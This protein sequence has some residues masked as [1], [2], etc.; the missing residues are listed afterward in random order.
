MKRFIARAVVVLAILAISPLAIAQFW[1]AIRL[2][3]QNWQAEQ[4]DGTVISLHQSEA[5]AVESCQRWALDNIQD[6]IVPVCITR[7]N[8][9]IWRPTT[10][11]AQTIINAGKFTATDSGVIDTRYPDG[12]DGAAPTFEWAT[13]P[14]FTNKVEGTPF[15]VDLRATYLTEP[16]T[17]DATLSIIGCTLSGG[18]SF[19]SPD[20]AYSDTGT[21]SLTGCQARAVREGVTVDSNA[22]SVESVAAE[23][24]GTDTTAPTQIVIKAVDLDGSDQPVISFYAPA[25]PEVADE[26]VSGLAT[27]TVLRD[28][29]PLTPT[30]FTGSDTPGLTYTAATVGTVNNPSN[31]PDPPLGVDFTIG[32]DGGNS[33][34]GSNFHWVYA[35]VA[36]DFTS[37]IKVTSETGGTQA[38]RGGNL[39]VREGTAAGSRQVCIHHH[40]DSGNVRSY[41]RNTT[42][43]AVVQDGLTAFTAPGC[44]AIT[45]IGSVI[46]TLSS[47]DTDCRNLAT[48]LSQTLNLNPTVLV[49][50]A[51]NSN[52]NGTPVSVV[53]ANVT[54]NTLPVQ[55]FT[56]TGATAGTTPS[57][58]IISDDVDGNVA[59]ASA[60]GSI[61]V[62]A[63]SPPTGDRY[64][65]EYTDPVAGVTLLGGRTNT[66]V[67]VGQLA[68][69]L[70][71]QDCGETLQLADG[72]HTG[73]HTI[74]A[75]CAANNPFVVECLN[76]LQCTA[77]GAWTMGG[78]RNIVTGILFSGTAVRINIGGT[79]NKFIANEVTGSNGGPNISLSRNGSTPEV[80]YNEIHTPAGFGGATTGNRQA[81]RT[82]DDGPADFPYDGWIHHNYIHDWIDKPVPT[83]YSSGQTDA[84]EICET[85]R[86]DYPTIDS[87]YWIEY[88]RIED[89]PQGTQIGAATVDFKCGGVVAAYNTFINVP[90]NLDQRGGTLHGSIF[91][92]NYFDVNSDG[93]RAHGYDNVF[94]GNAIKNTGAYDVMSG[95]LTG[96]PVCSQ[97]N[98]AG[99]HS[100]ASDNR[101]SGN[102]GKLIV[103][104][105]F[106]PEGNYD[107]PARNTLIEQHTGAISLI[108]GH[109]TGTVDNRNSDTAL[110]FT[111]AAILPTT[112][113]GPDALDDA[114]AAYKA[115]RGF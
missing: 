74:N 9:T 108:A 50:P 45:R 71:D 104:K 24:P 42:D 29:T 46:T 18:W 57:Y 88:N 100:C 89:H 86:F 66:S 3:A 36:G 90:G 43:G 114:S 77:T 1:E 85:S 98:Q 28:G 38:N 55:S 93:M 22:F 107:E 14:S 95:N 2:G 27:F 33:I 26:D 21:A 19:V 47:D 13:I 99:G 6:D 64:S 63:G 23:T 34:D 40:A 87:G 109:H 67:T 44:L 49:G 79:N 12:D 115:A 25:D 48:N 61:E 7:H 106:N 16:G 112:A 83:N 80:A 78:A 81:I 70:G 110:P 84:I 59:T 68:T 20:L 17:P 69:A 37:I 113:V 58:T 65:D 10:A 92:S 62:P 53:N 75:T 4:A 39:C 111:P 30:A 54:L 96:N 8:G 102:E 105:F 56:D 31:S 103:G 35:P 73:N 60:A 101:F 82:V 97:Q 72:T 76:A 94:I 15:T 91:E 41:T 51:S 11:L 52:Q 5:E 32:A